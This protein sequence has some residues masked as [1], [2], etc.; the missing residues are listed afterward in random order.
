MVK[1]GDA[2]GHAGQSKP[3]PQLNQTVSNDSDSW[4]ST[5][6]RPKQKHVV[7]RISSRV[8]SSKA[9]QKSA[10][11]SAQYNSQTRQQTADSPEQPLERPPMLSSAHR[12]TTSDLRLSR[13]P[14]A[15]NLKKNT[16]HTNLKRNRSHV[17][18]GKKS[19]SAANIKRSSSHKEVSKLKGSK[20]SVHFDLGNDGHDDEWVDASGSAS[21][22][23]SRRGSVV[24]SGQGSAKP[25]DRE[26]SRPQTPHTTTHEPLKETPDRERVQHK[27]YLTSRLLQRTPSH[28]APPK[29]SSETAQARP[30]SISPDSAISRA[31][32]TVYGSPKVANASIGA[33][34]DELT[35]RFVTGP[36]SGVNPD[37]GS[38]YSPTRAITRVKR[39]QSLGNMHAEHR[40]SVTDDPDEE[41]DSALAPRTRKRLGYKAA[42]ADISRTQQKLNL[43]RAS[44]SIEPVPVGGGGVGAVGASPLLGGAGYDNRDPR[45]GKLI[46]RTGQEYLV[47]RRYQNPIAR[48][49]ARLQQLPDADK[50]QHIPKQNG[51]NGSLHSKKPSELGVARYGHNSSLADAHRS[52]PA[53]P[54]RNVSVRTN[55]ANSSYETE[56]NR[57]GLSGSSYVEGDDDGVAALLRNLWDK[58]MDLSASQD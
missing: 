47:V 46:E 58:N 49:I 20:G 38:F 8:P 37:T 23:L 24:S 19:K 52:R 50:T 15:S 43:Q 36:G 7:G 3:R 2:S 33:P 29:M 34:G 27:E 51:T 44:S 54:R 6:H 56:G 35:S 40:S 53:T 30:R 22:Y 1:D 45:I 16:S 13:D 41:D 42:P 18:V 17:E 11:L 48:S 9:L 55:G 5:H 25:D 32:S 26:N 31:S 57:A 12:R 21:P 10:K 4:E 14:S 28:S 39:P